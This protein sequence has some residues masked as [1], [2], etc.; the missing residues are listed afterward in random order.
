MAAQVDRT[1]VRDPRIVPLWQK[2]RLACRQILDG[3][4][5]GRCPKCGR[6]FDPNDPRTFSP[7]RLISGLHPEHY[8]YTA[9]LGWMLVFAF[10]FGLVWFVGLLLSNIL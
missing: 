2:Y 1:Q 8:R 5:D 9:I 6:P 10:L 7:P 4:Q 3:A